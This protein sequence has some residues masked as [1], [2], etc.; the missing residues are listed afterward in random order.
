MNVKHIVL[1]QNRLIFLDE[2]MAELRTGNF[3]LTTYISYSPSFSFSLS[4]SLSRAVFNLCRIENL[5]GG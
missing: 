1:E 2:A 5:D 4:L 3:K